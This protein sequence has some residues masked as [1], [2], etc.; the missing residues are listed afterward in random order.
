MRTELKVLQ[1]LFSEPDENGEQRC[2]KKN[3]I[4][5]QDVWTENILAHSQIYNERGRILKSQCMV[6]VDKVGP[7]L[8][9]HSYEYITKIRDDEYRTTN[10][11][12]RYKGKK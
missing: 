2:I 6:L 9:K 3:L 4:I 7:L 5:K 11:G 8:V 12:F 10:V 1:N